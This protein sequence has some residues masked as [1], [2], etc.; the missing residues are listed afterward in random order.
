MIDEVVV[1]IKY[2]N[3]RC[4]RELIEDYN[5]LSTIYVLKFDSEGI[6]MHSQNCQERSIIQEQK[7]WHTDE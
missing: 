3:E 1:R 5:Q 7:S 6:V 4:M 2:H